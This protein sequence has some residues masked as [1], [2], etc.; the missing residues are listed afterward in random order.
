MTYQEAKDAIFWRRLIGGCVFFGALL[1][2]TLSTLLFIYALASE[3]AGPLFGP[4]YHLLKSAVIW[5]YNHTSI[6]GFLWDMAPRINGRMEA[7]NGNLSFA[8]LYAVLIISA[9]YKGSIVE[10]QHLVK[11]VETEAKK[12]Q[13]IAS[14][15]GAASLTQAQMLQ[16]AQISAP[17]VYG[18]FHT[19]YFAP[20]VVGCIILAVGKLSGMA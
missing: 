14:M 4:I 17:P 19:A 10:L 18:R 7:T 9:C 8:F 2:I 16:N 6:I 13:M 5:L 3:N 20:I 12:A 11:E 15:Q 1:V